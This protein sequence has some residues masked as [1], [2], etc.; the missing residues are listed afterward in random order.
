MSYL[1]YFEPKIQK[2]PLVINLNTKEIHK[3]QVYI[4]RIILV[5]DGFKHKKTPIHILE[6]VYRG[7]S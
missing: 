6:N 2:Y 5:V 1:G 3:E 4:L 7:R